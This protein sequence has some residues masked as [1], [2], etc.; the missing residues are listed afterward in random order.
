MRNSKSVIEYAICCSAHFA[1]FWYYNHIQ[2]MHKRSVKICK[3]WRTSE[4]KVC[5][6]YTT[7]YRPCCLRKAIPFIVYSLP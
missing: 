3:V 6:I 5:N 2:F 1:I 4:F 7:N